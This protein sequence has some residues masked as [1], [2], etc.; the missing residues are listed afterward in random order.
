[1]DTGISTLRYK[2]Y[3]KLGAVQDVLEVL[4]DPD[5][6]DLWNALSGTEPRSFLDLLVATQWSSLRLEMTLDSLLYAQLLREKSSVMGNHYQLRE[7]K[8]HR[9]LGLV[10]RMAL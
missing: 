2:S 7:S 5:N 6:S 1:M 10:R 4:A 3:R 8:F 9:V